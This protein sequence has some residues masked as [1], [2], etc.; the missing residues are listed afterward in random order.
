MPEVLPVGDSDH[1]GVFVT[2]FTRSPSIKPKTIMKR[3]YKEF[4]AE[5]FLNDVT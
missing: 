4:V 1:L 5:N 3:S 2:K